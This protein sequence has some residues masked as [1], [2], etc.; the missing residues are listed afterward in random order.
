DVKPLRRVLDLTC[1]TEI[2]NFE[3]FPWGIRGDQH[4]VCG[5]EVPVNNASVM[6]RL[7]HRTKTAEH[8]ADPRRWQGSI[9]SKQCIQRLGLNVFHYGDRAAVSIH[10][11]LVKFDGVAMSES[12]KT[13]DLPLEDAPV[14]RVR[15]ELFMQ[16]LNYD[17]TLGLALPCQIGAAHPAFAEETNDFIATQNQARSHTDLLTTILLD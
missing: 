8:A 1:Q 15:R 13:V 10:G 2:Q 11:C 17:Q 16:D 5:L 14:V 4:D 9:A 6:R 7:K 12:R 3:A